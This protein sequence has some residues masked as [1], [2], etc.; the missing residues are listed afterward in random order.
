MGRGRCTFAFLQYLTVAPRHRPTVAIRYYSAR[1]DI[2]PYKGIGIKFEDC[3]NP[4]TIF[5]GPPLSPLLSCGHFPPWGN[6]FL[7]GRQAVAVETLFYR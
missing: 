7:E 2:A 4:S 1:R 6:N 5:D 3:T